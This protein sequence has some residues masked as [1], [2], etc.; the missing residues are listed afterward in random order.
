MHIQQR[1]EE[2][3]LRQMEQERRRDAENEEKRRGAAQ[4]RVRFLERDRRL[5]EERLAR[6]KAKEE[7]E[8]RKKQRLQRLK[9]QV[10]LKV[11][12]VEVSLGKLTHYADSSR[13]QI[14][15]FFNSVVT[16]IGLVLH[17]TVSTQSLQN[18]FT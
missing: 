15:E 14:D 13:R 8:K 9:S 4:E 7:E 17:K 16:S 3:L 10:G 18:I 5:M 12:L 11:R 6:E 1:K 2:D